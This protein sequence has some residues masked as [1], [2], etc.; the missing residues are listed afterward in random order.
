MTVPVRVLRARVDPA[1]RAV[2]ASPASLVYADGGAPGDDRPPQVRAASAVRRQGERLVVV[3]DDVNIL[4]LHADGGAGAVLLPVG[5]GGLRAFGEDRGNKAAKMDLEAC[6][7]LPDGRLVAFG[8]GSTRRRERLVVLDVAGAAHI[9][10]ASP[11]YAA[12]REHTAFSG[13]E[14]NLE[15]AVVVGDRLRLFERGNGAAR[16]DL[17][18][19]NATA[20]LDLDDFLRFLAAC[21]SAPA[22]AAPPVLLAIVCFEL[23]AVAGTPLGFTDAALTVDG[24]VAFVACA[25]ASPDTFNDGAV[26]GSRFGLI[27]GDDVRTADIRD[28][29]GVPTYLK[30]E[31]IESTHDAT[32]YIVVADMDRPHEPATERLEPGLVKRRMDPA[33]ES[34]PE[35][36]RGASPRASHLQPGTSCVLGS[37]RRVEAPARAPLRPAVRSLRRR[38]RSRKRASAGAP[39]PYVRERVVAWRSSRARCGR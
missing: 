14:L 25:E 30:L 34:T 36:P 7:A 16:G 24:H 37:S 39:L 1:L 8:S 28:E 11:L 15:G 19:V 18:P 33:P 27:T 10:D 12:L 3:Q 21:A 32:R 9:V 23:G 20:D 5:D 38:V 22:T 6:A 4:A 13:S 31:G 35:R 29:S 26:L 17:A 2:I